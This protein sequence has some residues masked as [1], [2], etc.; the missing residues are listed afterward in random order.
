MYYSAIGL[1]AWLV[2]L[3][4]NQDILLNRNQTFERPAWK[5][6]RRFLVA[7]QVYYI[8][9]IIWG[10]LENRKLAT[11]LFVD[12]SVYFVS[13]AFCVLFWTRYVVDYMES[14]EKQTGRFLVGSGRVIATL[15]TALTGVNIFTPVLFTV[16]EQCVY[17]ALAGRYIILSLQILLLVLVSIRAFYAMIHTRKTDVYHA[18]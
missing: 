6:Y 2:L 16:D 15:V 5:T 4:E 12:T 1:L 18:R 10:V 3:I 14:G 7:V 8:T 13:M 9:D 11:L 17:H